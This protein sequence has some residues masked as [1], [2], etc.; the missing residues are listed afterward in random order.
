MMQ[1][2]GP[3]V[4]GPLRDKPPERR[5]YLKMRGGPHQQVPGG[6]HHLL[7]AIVETGLGER[8]RGQQLQQRFGKVGGGCHQLRV[9]EALDPD[10]EVEGALAELRL[11]GSGGSGR[12]SLPGCRRW[13]ARPRASPPLPVR[14]RGLAAHQPG[15]GC[16]HFGCL[17]L[18]PAI[19]AFLRKHDGQD[20][21]GHGG[22][23]R[24]GRGHPQFAVIGSRP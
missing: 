18:R 23:G 8:G 11:A 16:R 21:A 15:A 7:G 2:A 13:R 24:I 9:G 4:R 6:G 17:Q 20:A 10:R 14:P 19:S 22:V 12:A 3:A 1:S 5:S